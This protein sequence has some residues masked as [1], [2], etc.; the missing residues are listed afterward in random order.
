M[1]M[2]L[3]SA[4]AGKAQMAHDIAVLFQDSEGENQSMA[5]GPSEYISE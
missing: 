2:L 5:S 4:L 3:A 1:P